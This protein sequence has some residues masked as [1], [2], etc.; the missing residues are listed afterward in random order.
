MA[1]INRVIVTGNLVYDPRQ[2]TDQ[3]CPTRPLCEMRLAVTTRVRDGNDTLYIDVVAW[4]K[5]AE[6]CLRYLKKGSWILV[7]G[8]LKSNEFASDS[9]R[10]TDDIEIIAHR[11]LFLDRSDLAPRVSSR[12]E[13]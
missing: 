5:Q 12:P 10:K 1:G 2:K 9:G 4:E 8:K 13:E 7:E 11:V 6:S 3:N